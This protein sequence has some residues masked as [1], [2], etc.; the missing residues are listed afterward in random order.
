M[1]A[2]KHYS[3]ATKKFEIPHLANNNAFIGD[4][5]GS[6]ADTAMPVAC[7]LFKMS[8]GEPLTYTYTYDEMKIIIEGDFTIEDTTGQKVTAGPGDIFYF[9]NGATITFTTEKGALAFY[10]GGKKEGTF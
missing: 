9:P 4:I 2:F 1:S 3:E 6:P 7:G 5:Y 8:P 10:T